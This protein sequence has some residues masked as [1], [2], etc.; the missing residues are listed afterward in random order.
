[1]VRL[2]WNGAVPEMNMDN[3]DSGEGWATGNSEEDGIFWFGQ[4][5]FYGLELDFTRKTFVESGFDGGPLPEI[6]G[7]WSVIR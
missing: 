4:N 2:R 5:K 1:M 7:S 3:T 6:A